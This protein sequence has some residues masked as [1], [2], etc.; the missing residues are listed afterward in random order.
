MLGNALV[1]CVAADVEGTLP[2]LEQSSGSGGAQSLRGFV[3]RKLAGPW[4]FIHAGEEG[5]AATSSQPGVTEGM[6]GSLADRK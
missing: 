6:H 1:S 4:D 3:G 2:K 5:V